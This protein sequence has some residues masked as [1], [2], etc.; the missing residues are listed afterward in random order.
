VLGNFS[1]RDKLER[2][3]LAKFGQTCTNLGSTGQCPVPRLAEPVNRPL[4]GIRWGA[5]AI[6]HQTVRC[7]PD[8]PMCQPRAWPT[9]SHAIIDYHVCRANGHYV[10]SDC[11]VRHRTVQCIMEPMAV[12]DQ[13]CKERKE[14]AHCSLSGVHWTVSCAIDRR[15]PGPSKWRTNISLGPWGYKRPP[16]RMEQLPNHSL[17][18]LQHR[19]P[20]TTLL[21]F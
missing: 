2:R 16:R 3:S 15:H 19:D 17:N 8:C 7:A 12:S 14:I 18:I 10:A 1:I 13:L 21:L 9:A 4:S 6:I 11:L 20:A 5:A